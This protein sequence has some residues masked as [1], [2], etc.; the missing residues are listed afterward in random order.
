A[1][2]DPNASGDGRDACLYSG[3]PCLPVTDHM[4]ILCI[5]TYLKGEA[6]IRECHRLGCRVVLLTVE[7]LADAAWPREA[8]AEIHTIRRDSTDDQIRRRVG[9][10][11][12]RSRIDRLAAL[13][14]FDV[15]MAGMLR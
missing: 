3:G 4:T 2:D 5:A 10:L 8:I 12:R 11:T 7:T 9:A 1:R 6:F 14:D 15:E 13:D